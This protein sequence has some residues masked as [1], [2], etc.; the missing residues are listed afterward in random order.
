MLGQSEVK[1]GTLME[2]RIYPN[3]PAVMFY[4]FLTNGEPNAG[5]GVFLLGMKTLENLK[6]SF[7]MFG[8]DA[9]AIIFNR[10]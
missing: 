3:L 6:D 9:Y 2:F 4:N 8:I 10:K 5:A 7:W 1:S